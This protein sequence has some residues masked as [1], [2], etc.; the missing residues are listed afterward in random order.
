MSSERPSSDAGPGS[1]SVTSRELAAL[2]DGRRDLVDD[3]MREGIEGDDDLGAALAALRDERDAISVALKRAQPELGGLDGDDVAD[4]VARAMAKADAPDVVRISPRG[5]GWGSVAGG[6]A[7]VGSAIAWIALQ[8]TFTAPITEASAMVRLAWSLGATLDRVVSL[9]PGGW[10]SIASVALALGA[11]MLWGLRLIEHGKRIALPAAGALFFVVLLG[12]GR[13]RAYDIEGTW[14]S[15]DPLVDVDVDGQSLPAAL[16]AATRSCNLGL[17][18]RLEDTRRVTLH[19]HRVPLRE[20]LDAMLGDAP[21]VVRHTGHMIV[22]SPPERGTERAA[23]AD[24]GAGP[25]RI[26]SALRGGGADEDTDDGRF[27]IEALRG[28]ADREPDGEAPGASLPLRIPATLQAPVAPPPPP[29][30]PAPMPL[31]VP[32]AAPATSLPPARIDDLLTFGGDAHVRAGDDVRDVV[33]MGG[34]ARVEGRAFGNVVTMGGDADVAGTV[35]GDVVTM[36]GD[37]HIRPTGVVHGRLQ[38]MGGDVVREDGGAVSLSVQGSAA[39]QWSD[40][41]G[42]GGGLFAYVVETAEAGLRYALLFL[43]AL[44]FAFFAPERFGRLHQAVRRAPLR[45]I[46]GGAVGL[47]AAG[48]LSVVLCITIIGIPVAFVLGLT[49][50]VAACAGLATVGHLLG[51]ALPVKA[52]EDKPVVRLATGILVLFL[53]T[54]VPFFGWLAFLIALTIGVGAVVLTRFGKNDVSVDP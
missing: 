51:M 23:A 17:V 24:E 6:L 40:A 35:V 30:P 28:P 48:L 45:S 10:T 19:A 26:P 22:V 29:A 15:R 25:L 21:A 8:E 1:G 52:L 31:A 4:L 12:A 47:L 16:E 9:V 11:A 34:D 46:A 42:E 32:L 14:P 44:L 7:V 49:A 37:I 36:G 18:Y 20:V 27:R 53:V 5:L 2:I 50:F 54:R 41:P 43:G 13:A 39:P 38:T 33:T 3:T